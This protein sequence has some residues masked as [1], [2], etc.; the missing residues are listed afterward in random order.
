MR[1]LSWVLEEIA[2]VVGIFSPVNL[3][4]LHH[5][6]LTKLLQVNPLAG[7]K[8]GQEGI[9]VCRQTKTFPATQICYC[10]GF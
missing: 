3:L 6:L 9:L 4:N 7:P 10:N 1:D 5:L 2:Q 8:K